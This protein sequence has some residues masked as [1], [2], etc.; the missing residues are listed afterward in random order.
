MHFIDI[1]RDSFVDANHNGIDDSLEY[2]SDLFEHAGMHHVSPH[3]RHNADG[4]LTW[5]D[6][7]GNSAVMST[8]GWWQRNPS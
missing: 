2:D 5:V 8:E 4:S 1:I 6:G 7:D 3:W